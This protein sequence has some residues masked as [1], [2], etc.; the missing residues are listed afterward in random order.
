MDDESGTR[1]TRRAMP[2]TSTS[3]DANHGDETRARGAD[4]S[5]FLTLM[6]DF[7]PTDVREPLVF[8]SWNANGLLNRVRDKVRGRSGVPREA[9][10][11]KEAIMKRKPD[12]IALQ[13]V[14]LKC[15]G[16]P[17]EGTGDGKW[18]VAV[19]RRR[20]LYRS[21]DVFVAKERSS[22][23]WTDGNRTAQATRRT[24]RG[25]KIRGR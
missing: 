13:E 11:L 15:A 12:V 8:M 24:E 5:S 18:C 10:A 25:R 19:A 2:S 3:N 6:N 4:D 22:A 20:R 16:G 7:S 14:W 23:G 21:L 17:S 9:M 1:T